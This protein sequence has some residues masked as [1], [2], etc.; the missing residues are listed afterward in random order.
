MSANA[1]THVNKWDLIW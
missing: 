1:L